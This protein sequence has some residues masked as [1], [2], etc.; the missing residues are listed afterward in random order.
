[1]VVDTETTGLP[2][3]RN[4]PPSSFNNWDSCRLVQVAW[5]VHERDTG[6]LLSKQ[7]LVVKPV[8]F[9]ISN[10]HIHGITTE[11]AQEHGVLIG[12]VFEALASALSGVDVIVTHNVEFDKGVLLAELY[13]SMDV[14][15]G[16]GEYGRLSQRFCFIST[17]C[18]MR[19]ATKKLQHTGDKWLKLVELYT[20][21][22]PREAPPARLHCADADVEL[23]AKCYFAMIVL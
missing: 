10:A 19:M 23:C 11:F 3:R 13:R 21:L 22:F 16:D 15:D 17:Q 8:G 2:L 5:Q 1:M 12:A 7:Q 9:D 18:T 6:A 20:R 14:S 4:Q